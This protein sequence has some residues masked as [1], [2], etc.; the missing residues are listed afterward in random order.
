[1][2]R[3]YRGADRASPDAHGLLIAAA[4]EL[5]R[6]WDLA[7]TQPDGVLTIPADENGDGRREGI[8]SLA[9]SDDGSVLVIGA[10]DGAVHVEDVATGAEQATLRGHDQAVASLAC[11][12]R[13]SVIVSG[14][15]D[16][17]V[18]VWDASTA[19][20][21]QTLA[22]GQESV[23]VVALDRT[24]ARVVALLNDASVRVWDLGTGTSIATR[25]GPRDRVF[26]LGLSPDGASCCWA[27]AGGNYRVWESATGKKLHGFRDEKAG[28]VRSLAL[29]ADGALLTAAAD[30]AESALR[31]WRLAD[32]AVQAD[33]PGSGTPRAMAFS[34]DGKRL[35]VGTWDGKVQLWDVSSGRLLLSLDRGGAQISCI[36]FSADGHR[37]ACGGLDGRVA[38]WDAPPPPGTSAAGNPPR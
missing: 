18:R 15:L 30:Y 24:R 9:L 20:A 28:R 21:R 10:A 19:T 35:A 31:V 33:L 14:S 3:H 7:G 23:A 38:I 12:P 34:P 25:D 32:T 2:D 22:C 13:A 27:S 6:W 5:V 26:A 16:G 4:D 11:D 29:S 36:A 1:M 8:T 37:L 17:T